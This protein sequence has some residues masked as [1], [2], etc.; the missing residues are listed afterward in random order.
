[1]EVYPMGCTEFCVYSTV[2]LV[3]VSIRLNA[4]MPPAYG[5][6]SIFSESEYVAKEDIPFSEAQQL[7]Y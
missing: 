4:S 6:V 2:A 3:P 1:M 5:V 7:S